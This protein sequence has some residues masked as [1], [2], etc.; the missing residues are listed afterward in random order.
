MAPI[1]TI[2]ESAGDIVELFFDDPVTRF[3]VLIRAKNLV[4][5]DERPMAAN[6]H[7]MGAKVSMRR[8]MTPAKYHARVP[9]N[10]TK[11]P[12]SE[13]LLKS[14]NNPTGANG[15]RMCKSKKKEVQVV[16]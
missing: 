2:S 3:D 6:T 1:I 16:G 14:E 12:P 7:A 5:I 15:T 11:I 4:K 13:I 9:Y 10:I 8:T